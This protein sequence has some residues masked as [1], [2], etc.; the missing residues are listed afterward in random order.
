MSQP[1][2]SVVIPTY[3]R[4]QFLPRAIETALNQTV[5]DLEVVVVD[6]GSDTEYA[7]DAVEDYSD[8]VQFETHDAN[9]GLSAARNTGIDHANGTYIAFLDDDD[10]WHESKL[11]AQIHALEADPNGV[12]ATCRTVSITPG[13]HILRCEGERPSGDLSETILV[14][15]V[16]GSPSRV[17]IPADVLDEVRFD[18]DLQTK[19]DWDF[20]I[21]LCQRGMVRTVSKWYCYRMIHESMSSDPKSAKRDIRKVLDKHARL[22]REAG[23]WEQAWARYRTRVGRSYLDTGNRREARDQFN[24]ALRAQLQVKSA[25]LYGM[26]FLPTRAVESCIDMKRSLERLTKGCGKVTLQS[27]VDLDTSLSSR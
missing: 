20:Y 18:E 7:R 5:A 10:L 2:V 13:G 24:R 22:I 8:I 17:V 19:Q 12:I 1:V 23:L 14:S 15:N 6:D 25:F 11:Q 27:G 9:R 26:T 3:N 21:R 4:P 16:I